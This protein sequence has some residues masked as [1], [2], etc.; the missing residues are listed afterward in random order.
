MYAFGMM[1]ETQTER[2]KMEM[3]IQAVKGMYFSAIRNRDDKSFVGQIESVKNMGMQGKM[4]VVKLADTGKYASVYLDEC[5]DYA[6]SD[7]E[8]PA[9]PGR[10]E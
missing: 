2:V 1:T 6:W 8:L 3:T 9:L 10:G 4:V 7:F 5:Y